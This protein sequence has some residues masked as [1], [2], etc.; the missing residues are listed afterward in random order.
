MNSPSQNQTVAAGTDAQFRETHWS[1]VMAAADPNTGR[2]QIALETLCR[3]YWYPLYA[4]LRRQGRTPEQAK[5]LTQ[6]FFVHILEKETLA[7][8][9][10][11]R[12]KFRTFLLTVL[13]HLVSDLREKEHALKRGGGQALISLDADEAEQRFACEPATELD[14]EKIFNRRWAMTVLD[15]VLARLA[16]EY[17]A[18]GKQALYEQIHDLLLDKKGAASQGEI[19]ARLGV[20]E[21]TINSEVFRL[22][23]RFRELFRAEIA[24]TV[25]DPSQIDEE[26]RDLFATLRS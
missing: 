12:G 25:A 24:A 17:T 20:K 9:R 10:R 11:E 13:R 8:A 23:Q 4:F 6:E 1:V 22:R 15:A 5:D 14:P 3:T 18:R 2:A 19:A 7:R 26:A 21:G 16:G